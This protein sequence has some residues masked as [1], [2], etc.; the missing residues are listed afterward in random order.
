[1]P[2]VPIEISKERYLFRSSFVFDR[3]KSEGYFK[4]FLQVQKY[5]KSE[6]QHLDWELR[7]EWGI[8]EG[9][10]KVAQESKINPILLFL[11]PKVLS[12]CPEFLKY[13]RSVALLPQKGLKTISGVSNIENIEKGKS[14]PDKAQSDKLIKN[15]NEVVSLIV[16]LS[17][18]EIEGMMYATAGT[19]IDG[20]WRNQV[21]D[22][23]ER[24]I[25][26]II[27]DGL[28]AHGEISS[29]TSKGNTEKLTS[30]NVDLLRSNLGKG[31]TLNLTNGYS[32]IFSSEPDI[33]LKDEKGE[34]IGAVEIKAGIDP[35]GALERHGAMTKSFENVRAEYPDAF[36]ILVAACITDEV[37][38]LLMATTLVSMAFVITTITSN[39]SEKRKF[40]N[41]VRS[42]LKLC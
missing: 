12:T 10:W 22:E 39:E 9:A 33:E 5:D 40:V 2:K 11:H 34:T 6:G 41:K 32:M 36:T 21:G 17:K 18:S 25:R 15:I 1:M 31:Q 29:L 14:R 3:L 42:I 16:T 24:V 20:S 4:L 8:S 28:L 35:A 38:R 27:F 7:N 13:Y 30:K 26:T 19:K 23:G 37:Q